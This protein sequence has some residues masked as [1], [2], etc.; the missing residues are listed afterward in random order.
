[1]QDFWGSPAGRYLKAWETVKMETLVSDVFGFHALQLG[2]PEL[3]ALAA[4]R[5]PHRWCAV[6]DPDDVSLGAKVRQAQLVCEPS[7]LPFPE[8]SLDLVAMPHTLE[9]HPDPHAVL[10]EVARVLVPEGRVV[11]CG[12][13]PNSLWGWRYRSSATKNGL[14]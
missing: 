11:I 3:D 2:L 6:H 9:L 5:M 12:L 10:R 7:A 13:N 14:V 1:M 4:N 8:A